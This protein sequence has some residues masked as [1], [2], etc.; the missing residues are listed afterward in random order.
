M[1][2]SKTHN[3]KWRKEPFP[4]IR[5]FLMQKPII[6]LDKQKLDPM[7]QLLNRPFLGW[8]SN[9][10]ASFY[11]LIE[12]Q[13]QTTIYFGI[14]FLIDN[15]ENTLHDLRYSTRNHLNFWKC[16]WISD[17]KTWFSFLYGIHPMST[18]HSLTK[19]TNYVN[20]CTWILTFE[21]KCWYWVTARLTDCL[22]TRF[23]VDILKQNQQTH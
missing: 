17:S 12:I 6:G 4:T 16:V 8:S 15:L 1:L 21:F 3:Q 10:I 2:K 20:T 23:G 18:V 9:K 22:L 5:V 7:W 19:Q 11:S 13:T 14:F